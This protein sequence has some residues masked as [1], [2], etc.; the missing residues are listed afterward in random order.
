M[1]ARCTPPPLSPPEIHA[2]RSTS[3]TNT[4]R[5]GWVGPE[6]ARTLP[7][8][9][10]YCRY[11]PRPKHA[12]RPAGAPI[13]TDAALQRHSYSCKYLVH[14]CQPP[15][16]HP[17]TTPSHWQVIAARRSSAQSA[18]QS[19]NAITGPSAQVGAAGALPGHA[20]C[21]MPA[22]HGPSPC[23]RQLRCPQP[24][25]PPPTP[26]TRCQQSFEAEGT[27]W[28]ST[29]QARPGPPTPPAACCACLQGS[30]ATPPYAQ[31]AH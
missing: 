1:S 15:T 3:G 4:G 20:P 31:G 7:T 28:R 21:A 13:S 26:H 17:T 29:S 8:A 14:G 5:R 18:Q 6:G 12:P 27:A 2:R 9:R 16:P 11:T 22:W 30:A 24:R 23:P 10:R 19:R 25:R